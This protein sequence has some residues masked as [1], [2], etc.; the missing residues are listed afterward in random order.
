MAKNFLYKPEHITLIN[1]AA[2]DTEIARE[3]LQSELEPGRVAKFAKGLLF[4]PAAL[5]A[6]V[7]AQNKALSRMGERDEAASEIAAKAILDVINAR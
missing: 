4:D 5:E 1:I 3:F 6:Q 7:D 2:D